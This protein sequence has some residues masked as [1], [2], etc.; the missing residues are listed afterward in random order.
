MGFSGWVF[1]IVGI[2][3]AWHLIKWGV[4]TSD[5]VKVEAEQKAQERA[6]EEARNEMER[7]RLEIIRDL[8]AA[9]DDSYI[10]YHQALE[11]GDKF[12]ATAKGRDFYARNRRFLANNSHHQVITDEV[13]IKSEVASGQLEPV[14][15]PNL[16]KL[17]VEELRD[18]FAIS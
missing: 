5:E 13:R 7:L 1:L 6:I 10:A 15:S 8:S 2:I 11:S 14:S 18:R 12:L 3:G 17:D 16:E 4:Q 9:W